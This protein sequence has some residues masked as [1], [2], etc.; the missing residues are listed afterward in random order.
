MVNSSFWNGKKVFVTGHSGFKGSWLSWWLSDL[1]ARVIGYSKDLNKEQKEFSDCI[2]SVFEK[3]YYGDVCDAKNLIGCLS[4]TEPEFVFHLAAQPIVRKS[5]QIPTDTFNSNFVGTLNVLEGA[6]TINAIK[7]V[8]IV[9]SDKCYKNEDLGV[10]FTEDDPLGGND[11]YS[12]SKACAEI[13]T[14]SYIRSFFTNEFQ[15]VGVASVRA[16]NIIGGGDWGEDRLIPD[17]ARGLL[18]NDVIK[19][20]SPNAV[21]PWQ[22]VLDALS[23]YLLLAENLSLNVKSFSGPWN[24][25]PPIAGCLPV[26]QIVDKFINTTD[27]QVEYEISSGH[28][29]Y[30]APKLLLDTTKTEKYLTWRPKLTI[31]DSLRYTREW[32]LSFCNGVSQSALLERQLQEYQNNM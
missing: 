26:Q 7:T 9:T 2:A 12:A 15:K 32:Y 6:R 10:P 1:G 19:V 17:L 31:D 16:G 21:R 27:I 22:F 13:L 11:P 24:F 18:N 4:E 3:T 20:R 29:M 28:L 14:Q 8:I 5:Y 30:E 23:G 25:G